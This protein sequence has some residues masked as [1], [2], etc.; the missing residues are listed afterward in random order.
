MRARLMVCLL[1]AGC[2]AQEQATDRYREQ[3]LQAAYEIGQVQMSCPEATP[4]ISSSETIQPPAN[5][6]QAYPGLQ[7]VYTTNVAGC[8]A[9][10]QYVIVCREDGS[11]C[12]PAA[13]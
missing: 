5:D 8:G 7:L 9:S 1:R 3:A 6:A 13:R 4:T 11:G 10:R 2:A 12:A